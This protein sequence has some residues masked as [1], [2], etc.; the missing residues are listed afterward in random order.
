[1]GKDQGFLNV[2]FQGNEEDIT[3]SCVTLNVCQLG[4]MIQTTKKRLLHVSIFCFPVAMCWSVGLL[5]AVGPAAK[6]F[7]I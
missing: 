5:E 4:F 2:V 1:M 3:T 7:V 6:G